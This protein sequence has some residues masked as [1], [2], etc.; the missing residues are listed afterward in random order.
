MPLSHFDIQ[1]AKPR[2]KAD[3]LSDGGGLYLFI[4]PSGSKLWRLKYRDHGAG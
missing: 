4:Q 1:A 3:K 2:D